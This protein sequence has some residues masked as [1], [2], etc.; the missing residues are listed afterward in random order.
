MLNAA[1]E[2]IHVVDAILNDVSATPTNAGCTSSA[3]VADCE[4]ECRNDNIADPDYTQAE[5][6]S[7]EEL[8]D[9]I[10][11]PDYTQPDEI[12]G[13]ESVT[14]APENAG[15][16]SSA[17]IVESENECRNDNI[18]D[19]DYTEPVDISDKVSDGPESPDAS[20]CTSVIPMSLP[21]CV[22]ENNALP[23]LL[24]FPVVSL[25]ERGVY[26]CNQWLLSHVS[27][28]ATVC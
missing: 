6:M 2:I 9:S 3:A 15:H 5:E 28:T 26:V 23:S 14:E 17:A 19:P 10:V 22:T 16:R 25:D 8:D 11:D 1:L 13:E 20:L 21:S 18:A 4:T 27:F 7:D 12:S 24:S